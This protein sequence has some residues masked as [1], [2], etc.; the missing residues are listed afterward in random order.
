MRRVVLFL[1]IITVLMQNVQPQDRTFDISGYIDA[2]VAWLGERTVSIG[3]TAL[4]TKESRFTFLT[5]R[6]NLL[7]SSEFGR[8]K[9]FA[10]IEFS[11][12]FSTEHETGNFQLFEAWTQYTF[13]DALKLRGG[14]ITTPFGVF[15][16]T[17]DASPTFLGVI[18]PSVF[19]EGFEEV[20]FMPQFS[21]FLLFGTTSFGSV[22]IEYA[23][24]AGNGK[25]VEGETSIDINNEKDYGAR[26]GIVLS[27]YIRL[28]VSAWKSGMEEYE[29]NKKEV[30]T[31]YGTD[32]LLSTGDL[33]IRS[34]Y[35]PGF[36][37][38]NGN[39]FFKATFF[40][41]TSY[42]IDETVTPYVMFDYLRDD[43]HII[44]SHIQNRFS[45]GITVKPIWRTAL[46]VQYVLDSYTRPGVTD[47]SHIFMGVSILF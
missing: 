9:V 33:E 34:E 40:V 38:I 25:G 3:D 46:K 19:D 23:A 37:E 30:H 7:P 21:N 31:L 16:Q 14:I 42:N 29:D 41:I 6:F 43:A 13:S 44:L 39:K 24:F 11:N 2:G 17:R 32:F 47:N 35:M 12:G 8:F 1:V 26:F 28:G 15:N 22:Q 4:G 27:D 45:F 5:Q 10:N 36:A 18:P 20:D